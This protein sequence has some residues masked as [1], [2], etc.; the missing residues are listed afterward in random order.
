MIK[1]FRRFNEPSKPYLTNRNDRVNPLF[2][3]YG[4]LKK[5]N[6][7]NKENLIKKNRIKNRAIILPEINSSKTKS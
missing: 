7:F 2:S 1:E 6:N 5:E 3:N 4:F